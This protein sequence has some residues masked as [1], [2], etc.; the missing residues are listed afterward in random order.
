MLSLMHE[1]RD[2]ENEFNFDFVDSHNNPF[3]CK[4]ITVYGLSCSNYVRKENIIV[5]F[6]C[7]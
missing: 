7:I 4:S 3:I 2:H 1:I 6:C 5:T